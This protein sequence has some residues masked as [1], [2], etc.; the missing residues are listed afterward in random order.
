MRERRRKNKGKGYDLLITISPNGTVS[1]PVQAD[2][3]LA[4]A[5]AKALGD[6]RSAKACRSECGARAIRGKPMCG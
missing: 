5:I 1:I 3:G 4:V 6:L 2:R